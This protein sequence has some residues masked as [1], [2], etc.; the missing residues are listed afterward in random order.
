M[1]TTYNCVTR[2]FKSMLLSISKQDKKSVNVKTENKVINTIIRHITIKPFVCHFF[3]RFI[4]FFMILCLN[5]RCTKQTWERKRK[6]ERETKK[7]LQNNTLEATLECRQN[8]K[9]KHENGYDAVTSSYT[10][11]YMHI[12]YKHS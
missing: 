11:N 6:R 4:L 8:G 9:Q 7:P 1:Y 10:K 2:T 3:T 12:L 5:L